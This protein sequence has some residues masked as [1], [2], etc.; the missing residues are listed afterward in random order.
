MKKILLLIMIV[1]TSFTF[2]QRTASQSG[3]WNATST[4][5]GESLPTNRQ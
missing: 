1:S 4:W 5:N 2:S 3:D